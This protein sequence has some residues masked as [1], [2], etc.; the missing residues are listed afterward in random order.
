M[1]SIDNLEGAEYKTGLNL[2]MFFNIQV[3]EN[4]YIHPAVGVKS[5]MGAKGLPP[6]STGDE[7]LDGYFADGEVTRKL[8]YINVP[9]LARYQT[10]SGWGIEA[11][12]QMNVWPRKANDS[13]EASPEIG[14]DLGYVVDLKDNY[15]WLNFGGAVG[16]Y[17][18]L[19]KGNGMTINIRYSR[20]FTDILKDNPGDALHNSL[21]TFKVD[22]PVGK[23]KE[24]E[25]V[26][27]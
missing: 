11:G 26:I 15:R 7:E 2:G 9:V 1:S 22:I 5:S 17:K 25:K 6:Y 14:G 19:K 3:A 24:E 12:P 21:F 10:P 16:I 23:E 27:E 4:F 20:D 18:K 13:F 8:S